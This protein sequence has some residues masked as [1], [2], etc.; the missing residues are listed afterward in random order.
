M[1]ARTGSGTVGNQAAEVAAATSSGADVGVVTG[2]QV[3]DD[4][5]TEQVGDQVDLR[6][7]A[8]AGY[9]NGLI[10]LRFFWAPAAERCALT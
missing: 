5:A 10:L 3:Q 1:P 7:A 9:A 4:R 6:A 8:A 2:G